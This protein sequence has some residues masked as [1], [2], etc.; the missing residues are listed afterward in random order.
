MFGSKMYST[1][2]IIDPVEGTE[3]VIV[4]PRTT[5]TTFSPES[6]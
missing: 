6:E 3:P 1:H 4:H 2:Q 5:G